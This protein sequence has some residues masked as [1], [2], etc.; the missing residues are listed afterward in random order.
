[1][2]LFDGIESEEI[3]AN[4]VGQCVKLVRS[5]L[6]HIQEAG[7]ALG[8]RKSP[9]NRVLHSSRSCNVMKARYRALPPEET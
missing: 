7:E 1:M 3:S 4:K 9:S 8:L 6:W 5:V 2:L